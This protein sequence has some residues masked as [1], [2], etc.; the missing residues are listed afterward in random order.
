[1]LKRI[2]LSKNNLSG[3]FPTNLLTVFADG[4]VRGNHVNSLGNMYP[5]DKVGSIELTDEEV[6]SILSEPGEHITLSL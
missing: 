4:K 2:R 6:R 5:G 1:M 3:T